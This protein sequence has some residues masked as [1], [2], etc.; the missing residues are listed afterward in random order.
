MYSDIV[1]DKLSSISPVVLFKRSY[2]KSSAYL[3][4]RILRD[5]I[6]CNLY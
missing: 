3:C 2:I 5:N 1:N 6:Y 4:L